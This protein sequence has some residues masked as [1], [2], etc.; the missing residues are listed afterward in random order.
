MPGFP[1]QMAKLGFYARVLVDADDTPEA[2][3]IILR[4][5]GMP[6]VEISDFTAE[7]IG[8]YVA[9]ATRAGNP[10]TGLV[11]HAMFSPFPVQAAGRATLVLK[12]PTDEQLL[13]ILN[14]VQ[15]PA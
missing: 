12:T 2:L 9:D 11:A 13:A 8:E 10:I 5:P 4:N 15:A 1:G 6:D 7:K 3:S 14:F